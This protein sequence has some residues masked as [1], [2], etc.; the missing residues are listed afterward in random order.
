VGGSFCKPGN[1]KTRKPGLGA[2]VFWF[3]G[4]LV[5]QATDGLCAQIIFIIIG[6][7]TLMASVP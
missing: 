4:F 5:F 6:V 7:Q 1:Q 2:L 3:P